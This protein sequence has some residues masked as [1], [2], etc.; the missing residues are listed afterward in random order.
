[1]P[2]SHPRSAARKCSAGKPHSSIQV[3]P[4]TRPS[5]RSGLTAYA[6]LSREPNSFWPPSPRELTMWLIRLDAPHLRERLDRSDDGQDHTVLP[7][8]RLACPPHDR[9][10][11][12][13]LPE[14]CW[15]DEPDSAVR[16][17]AVTGSQGLPALPAPLAP[18]AAASTASPARNQDDSRPPLKDEPGW[19][20]HTPFPNFGKVEYFCEEG[21][22]R[23][24]VF[25]LRDAEL[26]GSGLV[27]TWRS[28]HASAVCALGHSRIRPHC[29]EGPCMAANK[30]TAVRTRLRRRSTAA[31]FSEPL[32]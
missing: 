7:Y 26:Y 15:R 18:D 27:A 23:W 14:A 2:T 1:M 8:A 29:L 13:T 4:I 31:D 16:L 32:G 17:H 30:V 28:R 22:T 9:P 3:V 12:S 25:C 24:R 21:L 10:A 11:S 6:V 5:L 20:T 19:A